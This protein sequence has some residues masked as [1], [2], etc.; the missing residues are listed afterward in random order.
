MAD[1]PTGTCPSC[2]AQVIW[3][4]TV[5]GRRIPVDVQPARGGNVALTARPGDLPPLAAVVSLAKQFGRQ[6][7][8]RMP[9][10]VTCPRNARRGRT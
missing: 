1:Y 7:T 10:H 6:G 2:P 9:H 8:L 5:A 3:A 4:E